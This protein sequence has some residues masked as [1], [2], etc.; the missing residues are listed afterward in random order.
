MTIVGRDTILT[1]QT[2]QIMVDHSIKFVY[3]YIIE[4]FDRT[5]NL[6]ESGWF[7]SEQ[8]AIWK[9]YFDYNAAAQLTRER[10][11]LDQGKI[12]EEISYRYDEQGNLIEKSSQ[13]E[14]IT[15]VNKRIYIYRDD[16]LTS[17]THYIN[18]SLRYIDT[19]ELDSND[20][21]IQ[22]VRHRPNGKI[23]FREIH[24]QVNQYYLKM[25]Y[26]YPFRDSSFFS[27]L[28]TYDDY[29]NPVSNTMIIEGQVK[30]DRMF[31]YERLNRL[32]QLISSDLNRKT[33]VI[34]SSKNV[35]VYNEQG[36]LLE[37]RFYVFEG[38]EAILTTITTYTYSYY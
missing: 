25:D 16:V 7:D 18:D 23:I 24:H 20:K 2:Q 22:R 19:Y 8:V 27:V 35:Y 28:E 3:E 10:H 32:D 36:R 14:H 37:D 12:F 6:I 5:G 15:E 11:C 30:K 34:R 29:D 21:I 38:F 9:E 1:A 26:F 13:H 4:N 17:M 31:R 33:G